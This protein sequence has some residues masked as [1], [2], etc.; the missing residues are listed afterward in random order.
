MGE[1]LL[2]WAPRQCEGQGIFLNTVCRRDEILYAWRL[3]D[4]LLYQRRKTTF[5]SVWVTGGIA[6]LAPKY[7]PWPSVEFG[8]VSRTEY[9][10]QDPWTDRSSVILSGSPMYS[11]EKRIATWLFWLTCWK[12][13]Y[14]CHHPR[15]FI[16]N[17]RF[18]SYTKTV[19]L[20]WQ[21]LVV[22]LK[23]DP[24]YSKGNRFCS[25][26]SKIVF[27]NSLYY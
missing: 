18:Y 23:K 25:D 22:F 5:Y 14:P 1:H 13:W 10:K 9:F 17:L 21:K 19:Q 11:I 16:N 6:R 26:C 7:K 2:F 27:S 24:L 3:N 20:S 8:I 15:F 12:T 4:I